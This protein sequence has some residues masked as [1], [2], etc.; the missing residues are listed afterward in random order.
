VRLRLTVEYDGTGFRGWAAQPGQRTVEQ[1]FRDAFDN[2]FPSWES[3]AVATQA[4]THSDR[5]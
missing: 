3:P 5:W 1:A 2:V 4:C